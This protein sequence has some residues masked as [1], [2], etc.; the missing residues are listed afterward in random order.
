M[1]NG[2]EIKKRVVSR[3]QYVNLASGNNNNNNNNN[4]YF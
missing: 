3:R 2:E 1:L 4:G